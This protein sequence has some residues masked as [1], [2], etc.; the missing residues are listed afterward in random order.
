M[1]DESPLTDEPAL[2]PAR[3]W[4]WL[5]MAAAAV[6]AGSLLFLNLDGHHKHLFGNDAINVYEEPPL[7]NWAHGWPWV[8][9]VRSSIYPLTGMRG[10]PT[11][12]QIAA[13]LGYYSRWPFDNAPVTVFSAP[14]LMNDCVIALAL[15]MGTGYLLHRLIGYGHMKF[16]LK[17]LLMATSAVALACAALFSAPAWA[18]AFGPDASAS[19][20]VRCAFYLFVMALMSAAACLTLHAV[21]DASRRAYLAFGPASSRTSTISQPTHEV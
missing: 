21:F 5:S 9:A 10:Q 17:G 13:P 2:R 4:H 20:H 18:R 19:T 14:A 11:P 12:P 8:C 6:A 15:T 7:I 1:S 3:R 16:G